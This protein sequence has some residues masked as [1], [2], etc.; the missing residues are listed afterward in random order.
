MTTDHDLSNAVARFVEHWVADRLAGRDADLAEYLRLYPGAESAVAKCFAELDALGPTAP[1]SVPDAPASDATSGVG[2]FRFLR[3]LGRGG[4]ATVYLAHDLRFD[5]RVAVKVLDGAG[6]RFEAAARRLKREAE[7]VGK[8]NHPALCAVFDAGFER[9][10]GFVAM[11]HVE[12]ETWQRRI[13]QRRE[14]SGLP[15][16]DEVRVATEFVAATA[17]ALHA[18]HE[19]GVVHRDVKPGNLMIAPDGAPVVLDFGLAHDAAADGAPLTATGEVFGT[20]GYMAPEQVR[21]ADGRPDRRIDVFALGASLY[22]AVTLKRAFDGPTRDAVLSAVV[23]DDPPDARRIN[24]AVGA[25]LAVV[26]ETAL[27]KEPRRRYATAAAFADDLGRVL[28]REP[29]LARPLGVVGRAALWARR[30]PAVASLLAVIVFGLAATTLWI[31]AK[32]RDLDAKNQDLSAQMEETLRLSDV[33]RIRDLKTWDERLWPVGPELIGGAEGVDAWLRAADDLLRRR[34]LH[35]ASAD[36]LGGPTTRSA[37]SIAAD[38]TDVEWRRELLAGL[39]SELDAL[40]AR[41]E[42]MR[43]RKELAAAVAAEAFEAFRSEWERTIADVAADARYGGLRLKPQTGLAPLGR[44]PA[45]GLFEFADRRTGT[46]AA[47]DAS[48]GRTTI[49][50]STGLVFVLIPGGT[51][52]MGAVPPDDERDVGDPN[53]DPHASRFEQPLNRVRLDP[54]LISKFEMTS[55]QWRRTA[56]TNATRDGFDDH[57][58]DPITLI[59]WNEASLML[60]RVGCDLPT[61]AQWEHASRAGTTTCWWTGDDSASLQGAANLSDAAAQGQRTFETPDLRLNDGFVTLAPVGSFRP[62]AF[63]LHDVIGNAAEWCRD[64]FLTYEAEARDGDGFRQGQ[65]VQPRVF[66]GGAFDNNFTTGTLAIRKA[67]R[68]HLGAPDLGLR[69]IRPFD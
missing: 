41:V 36:R 7:I 2:P 66:R 8:L 6:P 20:P 59:N 33:K 17:R 43:R 62:N 26:I 68:P 22:E 10:R 11:R 15:D 27:A 13:A 54:F 69:P 60:K 30:R 49:K 32:N 48:T 9:G 61:E 23:N 28:R 21:G 37:A 4:Q 18:A 56:L 57:S 53:V 12:G 45:S 67:F 16:K 50:A 34:P 65:G 14:R 5:R 52:T 55:G 42:A 38:A 19:A 44:D 35:A 29:V 24:P 46:L 64:E 63:G 25:D 40:V 47:R 1:P 3:E 31:D 58:V 39:L 51:F